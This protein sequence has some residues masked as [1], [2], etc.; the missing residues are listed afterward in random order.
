MCTLLYDLDYLWGEDYDYILLVGIPTMYSKLLWSLIDYENMHGFFQCNCR[1]ALQHIMP[2][3]ILKHIMPT[4]I[5]LFFPH[6]IW[7]I[8]G[9]K[10]S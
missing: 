4:N 8:I 6:D 2:M 9:K 3:G 5:F 1:V 7:C 10:N